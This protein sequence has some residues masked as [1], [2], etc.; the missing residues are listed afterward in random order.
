MGETIT[1]EEITR[2]HPDEWVFIGDIETNDALAIQSG[3]VLFHSPDRDLVYRKAIEMQPPGRTGFR[4]TGDIPDD[5]M[6]VL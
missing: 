3:I 1:Y 2:R 4:F 5:V 6:V